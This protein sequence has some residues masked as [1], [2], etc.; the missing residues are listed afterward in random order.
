MQMERDDVLDLFYEHPKAIIQGL[1]DVAF[2]FIPG[3]RDDR[4]LLVSHADTVWDGDGQRTVAVHDGKF[5]SMNA[6]GIGADDRAGCAGLYNLIN[7][8]HSILI[9][10][11]EEVG[12]QGSSWLMKHP[13]FRKIVSEHQF[14][15][16][17]DRAGTKDLVFYD[18]GTKEFVEYCESQM[19][20]YEFDIGSFTDIVRL[21]QNICG[22]N[23]SIGY[24]FEHTQREELTYSAWLRTVLKVKNWILGKN[25]PKF[26]FQQGQEYYKFHYDSYYGF[27]YSNRPYGGYSEYE[28]YEIQGGINTEAPKVQR[29]GEVTLDE[30]EQE[31]EKYVECPRCNNIISK[32]EADKPDAIC[33]LCNFPL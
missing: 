7:L 33:D 1:G 25:I 14:A 11:G 31:L 16:Q 12:C 19:E 21:C 17:L 13:G 6:L 27:G 2:C 22:V 8:G 5:K 30:L 28:P 20:G 24:E 18:N 15:I 32:E 29:L 9:P 23:I 10:T 3:T 4:V 26:P